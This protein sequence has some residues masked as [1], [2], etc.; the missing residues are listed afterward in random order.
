MFAQTVSETRCAS[1]LLGECRSA[2]TSPVFP[3]GTPLLCCAGSGTDASDGHHPPS[4][5]F[6]LF[7]HG[8]EVI[9]HVTN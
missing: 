1:G 3:L 5:L 8:S 2:G 7:K 4:T 6:V 9:G